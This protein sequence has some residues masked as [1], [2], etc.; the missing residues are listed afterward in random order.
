MPKLSIIIPS[1]D[2]KF[3]TPTIDDIFRNCRDESTEV[4]AVLDSDKWPGDWKEVTNRHPRLHTIHNGSPKGMRYAINAGVASAISRGAK[5]VAKFDGHCS[6]S[7]GFDVA[8]MADCDEDWIVVPRR[9]RLDPESWTATDTHKPDIDYHYLSFPSDPN[10][11]GGPGLNGK[12]WPD[13][14]IQRKDIPIDDEMSSQGSG[15]FMHASFFQRLGLMD[16]A[17]YGPFW[18]EFQEIGLCAWLSGGAVKVNK[19]CRY[20]H[21]HKGS[22]HGRGYKLPES[23]L[24]QGRN[25]TMKWIFN[26]AWSKQTIPF[27]WLIEKFWP[28]PGWPNDWRELLYKGGKEPW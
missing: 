10:D 6:F 11:F 5:Y 7:E 26:E 12:V 21:L 19:N 2:E 27:S 13:R 15:W 8:L 18:N 14:A 22:K 9:G 28:I 17:S 1:R 23:W 20:L 16:E 25:H 4:I 24:Q 3:L